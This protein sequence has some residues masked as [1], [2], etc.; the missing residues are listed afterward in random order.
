MLSLLGEK[1]IKDLAGLTYFNPQ[2]PVG[3]WNDDAYGNECIHMNIG[4]V[5]L[6]VITPEQVNHFS[7]AE[8]VDLAHRKK[9]T[10]YFTVIP[11]E[12]GKSFTDDEINVINKIGNLVEGAGGHYFAEYDDAITAILNYFK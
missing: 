10:I 12:H 3:T 2:L 8:V 11:E 5:I 7:Y 9:D 6:F 4:D 1:A